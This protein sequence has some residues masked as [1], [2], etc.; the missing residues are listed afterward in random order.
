MAV[1]VQ[2]ALQ[3]FVA[4][5]G[6][7]GGLELFYGALNTPTETAKIVLYVTQTLVGD[8]FVIYRL[9]IVWGRNLWIIILPICLL[10]SSAITGY[11]ACY[12]LGQTTADEGTFT[13]LLKPWTSAFFSISLCT[14]VVAT[15]LIAYRVWQSNHR[16]RQFRQE[17]SRFGAG[18][19]IE[20]MVQSAFIY[21]ATLATLLGT[22]LS[23][24]NAQFIALDSLQHVIGIVFTII[25]IRVG[26]GDRR[27]NFSN[28]TQTRDVPAT[29]VGRT[30]E[31]ALRPVAINVSVTRHNDRTSFDQFDGS[32]TQSIK[33]MDIET[34]SPD[35]L[36]TQHPR[37]V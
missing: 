27:Y 13:R 5:A 37:K 16:V 19:V 31:Y 14:N 9:C 15:T 22:Y 33:G 28:S 17:G 3:A 24:S 21:S 26:L 8:T 18:R 2:R 32:A 4:L 12:Q 10:I 34:G 11:G 36:D 29:T 35:S 23:N 20:T 6:Q 1:D 30:D 7:A 25:I